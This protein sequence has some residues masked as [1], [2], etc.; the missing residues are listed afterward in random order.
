[1]FGRVKKLK[2]ELELIKINNLELKKIKNVYL[3]Q[4]EDKEKY[5]SNLNLEKEKLISDISILKSKIR[6]IQGAK[7]GLTAENNKLN[8]LVDDL[9]K[10]LEESMSDKYRVKKIPSG[11]KP[12]G[13]TI[14]IKS[15]SR[16]SQI[17][18]NIYKED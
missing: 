15:S 1:M 11:R 13:N 6:K 9:T 7:G 18:K 3:D 12:K 10:K 16:Q 5:I 14:R 4:L 8:K 2:K 17:I